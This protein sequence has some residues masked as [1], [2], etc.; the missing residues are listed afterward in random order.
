[1][2]DKDLEFFCLAVDDQQ[3]LTQYAAAP[4]RAWVKSLPMSE[5]DR[6][7]QIFKKMGCKIRLRYRGPRFDSQRQTCLKANARS[8]AV[9]VDS[10]AKPQALQNRV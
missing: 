6:V 1:M 3:Y 5:L 2:M 7:Q 10:V 9:Y 8:F 4:E